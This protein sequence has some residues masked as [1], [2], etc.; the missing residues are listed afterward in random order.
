MHAWVCTGCSRVCVN[1]HNKAIA[2][3][4]AHVFACLCLCM[5][6]PLPRCVRV[7]VY[8]RA[9][10]CVSVCMRVSPCMSPFAS[11]RGDAHAHIKSTR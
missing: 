3:L 6:A 1:L 5:C 10:S 2:Y 4:H 9:R 11:M 7:N 8:V